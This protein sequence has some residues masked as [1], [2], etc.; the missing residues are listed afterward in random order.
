MRIRKR[1]VFC[2]I[3]VYMAMMLGFSAT[4]PAIAPGGQYAKLQW[5]Y[6]KT[7]AYDRDAAQRPATIKEVICVEGQP[8]GAPPGET[9]FV[10]AKGKS[11]NLSAILADGKAAGAGAVWISGDPDTAKVSAGKVTGVELGDTVVMVATADGS[12]SVAVNI[13]VK[14][15][16]ARLVANKSRAILKM[17]MPGQDSC[18][19]TVTPNARG[20]HGQY[21]F[22]ATDES[23]V[24]VEGAG[25]SAVITPRAQGKTTVTAKAVD[26]SGKTARIAVT[27][28]KM[29]LSFD[30]NPTSTE[31]IAYG[32]SVQFGHTVSPADASN[33]ELIWGV[34][35]KDYFKVDRNGKVTAKKKWD[36]SGVR[37]YTLVY[38]TPADGNVFVRK[39]IGAGGGGPESNAL[40]IY[41][42]RDSYTGLFFAEKDNS[43]SKFTSYIM[44]EKSSNGNIS[45][46]YTADGPSADVGSIDI[47]SSDD[48]VARLVYVPGKGCVIYSNAPGTATITVRAT[49]GSG[50]T[51]RLRV[52]VNAKGSLAA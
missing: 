51:A 29:V 20:A 16:P 44:N 31:G 12:Q 7:G 38:A 36:G 46:F 35:N 18:K 10:V 9:G 42:Y 28:K 2:A 13:A 39:Y 33:T 48:R 22:A 14:E 19:W 49:D 4:A 32:K 37:P 11:I 1:A 24:S 6:E 34:T 5:H 40:K 23:I 21:L 8:N 30:L 3:A 41:A 50:K 27:V 52:T 47:K 45:V 26:G 25:S 17:N 43:G 15:A